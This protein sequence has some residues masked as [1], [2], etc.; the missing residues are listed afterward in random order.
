M[1]AITIGKAEL[2]KS[3]FGESVEYAKD[4]TESDEI[5]EN[6]DVIL[7]KIMLENSTKMTA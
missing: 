7:L 4:Y 2:K 6:L 5:E 1:L 3:Y